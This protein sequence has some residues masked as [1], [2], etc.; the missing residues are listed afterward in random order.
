[1]A[2]PSSSS[3][4]LTT[5]G[6]TGWRLMAGLWLQACLTLN[7]TDHCNNDIV[8]MTIVKSTEMFDVR[9]FSPGEKD[10]FKKRKCFFYFF[11]KPLFSV[12]FHSP[13]FVLRSFTFSM[14]EFQEFCQTAF[15][16]KFSMVY[17]QGLNKPHMYIHIVSTKYIPLSLNFKQMK[18]TKKQEV[19]CLT[20]M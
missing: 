13:F 8:W 11:F 17:M 2:W 18:N 19:A 20:E 1:M 9:Q 10:G 16:V 15:N 14:R 12:C 4:P 3:S 5:E 7:W 6:V